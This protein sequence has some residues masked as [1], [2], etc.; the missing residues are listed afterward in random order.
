MNVT[1]KNAPVFAADLPAVP[2]T[3]CILLAGGFLTWL[4]AAGIV[5][6]F[7]TVLNL[8]KIVVNFNRNILYPHYNQYLEKSHTDEERRAFSNA[9]MQYTDAVYHYGIFHTNSLAMMSNI[10]FATKDRVL[11][12]NES[13]NFVASVMSRITIREAQKENQ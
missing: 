13:S 10:S 6:L 3:G 4:C 8:G 5:L 11:T 2:D 9:F 1:Q 7:I 12:R